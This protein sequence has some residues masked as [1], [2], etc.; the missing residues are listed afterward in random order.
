MRPRR[1]RVR[2]P[3]STTVS[4]SA[5]EPVGLRRGRGRPAPVR[6]SIGSSRRSPS[7]IRS[8]RRSSGRE[9]LV[10][11]QRRLAAAEHLDVRRETGA[12]SSTRAARAVR[13]GADADSEIVLP[14]PDREV[15]PAAAIVPTVVR[16]LVPA[17]AR[18]LDAL[19]HVLVVISA[20]R[21][22]QRARP[23]ACG[24]SASPASPG[25]RS[26]TGDRAQARAPSRCPGRV[27]RVSPGIPKR[28]SRLR[29]ATPGSRSVATAERTVSGVARRSSTSSSRAPKL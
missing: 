23:R 21:P 5:G 9:L 16:R 22:D 12:V 10:E 2:V 15:V 14:A 11:A 4:P 13:H 27:A 7:R 8:C 1:V 24:R 29:L 28:T 25:A 26:T 20:A 6:S 18:A 17:V 3:A 19:D